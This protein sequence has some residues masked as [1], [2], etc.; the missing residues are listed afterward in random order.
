MVLLGMNR[1]IIKDGSIGARLRFRAAAVD[2]AE[3][4]RRYKPARETYQMVADA[5]GTQLSE[6]CMIAAHPWDLIGARTAGCSAALIERAGHY[7]HIEQ[8][9]E[10]ARKTLAFIEGQ[11]G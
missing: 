9:D 8:A 10:F 5:T 6:L 2:G 7:P 1:I 4:V 3:T 11:S